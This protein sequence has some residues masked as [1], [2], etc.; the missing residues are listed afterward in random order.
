[1]S[2]IAGLLEYQCRAFPIV[3]EARTEVDA[4]AKVFKQV[5]QAAHKAPLDIHSGNIMPSMGRA[6]SHTLLRHLDIGQGQINQLYAPAFGLQT[7]GQS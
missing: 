6:L 5:V 4:V 7:L 1:M 3:H 2:R